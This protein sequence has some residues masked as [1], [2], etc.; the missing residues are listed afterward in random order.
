MKLDTAAFRKLRRLAPILDDILGAGEVEHVHHATSL[1]A[2]A[3]LC[4]EIFRAYHSLHP[5]DKKQAH[6][7]QHGVS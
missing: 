6:P 1:A 7:R 2:L 3:L 4:G 5:D